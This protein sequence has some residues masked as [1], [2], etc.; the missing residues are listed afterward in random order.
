MEWLKVPARARSV[1]VRTA[2]AATVVVAV[3]LACAAAALVL[4]QRQ[5]LQQGLTTV[6]RQQGEEVAAQIGAEGIDSVDIDSV[7]ATAGERALVQVVAPSGGVVTA[8]TTV[9][10]E[11]PVSSATPGP[12]ETVIQTLDGLPVGEDEPYVVVVTGVQT[13]RGVGWVITAQSLETVQRSTTVVLSLTGLG[14]PL[15]LVVVAFT[16]YWLA[17]RALAPVEAIRRRVGQVSA[18]D[19]SARVPVPDS[20]DEIARLAETMN[21]MLARLQAS[22]ESQRRFVAD[23]SHEL[24]SPLATIR[25]TAEVAGAHPEALDWPAAAGTVLAE[26][27]RLERL[28]NDLL[29]L[30]RADEDGLVLRVEDVDLDDIVTSEA[31]RLRHLAALD[32]VVDVRSVRVRGDLQHLVRAVRNLTDNAARHATTTIELHLRAAD[33]VA[34][35]DVVDDGPGIPETEHQRV[36]ERFVRLDSSR[37]RGTG[38][39]GLGLAIARQIVRAHGGDLDVAQ[40]QHAGARLVL[41]MPSSEVPTSE[42]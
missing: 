5:Q 31:A 15:V 2:V 38:G 3:A 4:L 8:S 33:G 27:D 34:R 32:V 14:Y 10:G 42:L 12:G 37:E 29:M 22:A 40:S 20:G 30:A 11:P 35:L 9:D 39:T 41:T 23:A 7:S 1:R 36:F 17:G 18:V 26:T 25:A 24:R 28:V 6:A 21:S 19:L 13:D 16:C